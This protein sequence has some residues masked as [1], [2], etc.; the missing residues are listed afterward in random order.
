MIEED[1]G[2][3]PPPL[4]ITT[5]TLTNAGVGT[6]YSAALGSTGGTAPINWTLAS[7]NLPAGL[8]L[9]SVGVISGTPTTS[10][11]ATFT[12][13]AADSATQTA[14][15]QLSL[16]VNATTLAITTAT[17]PNGTI[18]VAYS[19]TVQTGGGTAPVTLAHTAGSLPPGLTFSAGTISGT[20]TTVGSSSFTI[21]ATDAASQSVSRGFQLVI[22]ATPLTITTTSLTSGT[23]GVAYNAT[24]TASGGTAPRTWNLAGGTLPA[25]VSLNAA[26]AISGTPTATGSFTFNA[27]VTDAAGQSISRQFVLTINPPALSI[28]TPSLP[29]GTIGSAYSTGIATSGGVPPVTLTLASGTLPA[30]LGLAGATISGTPTTA[31]TSTFTIRATDA[32]AQ[33]V[34]RQFQIM[35]ASTPLVITSSALANG[36]TG[37]A[38][39]ANLAATGGVTPYDWSVSAGSLPA[40]LNLSAAGAITGTPTAF[41]TATFTAQVTDASSQVQARQFSLTV[42][43]PAVVINTATLPNAVVNSAYTTSIAVSGGIA[44]YA[45][46]LSSG[47]LPAG[48]NLNNGTGAISGTPTV[49]G[50][51]TFTISV[52]DASAQNVSRQFTLTVAPTS[53]VITTTGL[54]SGTNGVAYSRTLAA[55]GGVPGYTWNIVGSLPTGLALNAATGQISGTPTVNGTSTFVA[56]VT[57]TVPQTVS[58]QLSITINASNLSIDTL[59]LPDG[60]VS[61]AYN[62]TLV[63]SGGTAPYT[64]SISAGAAPSGLTLSAAG[65]LSGTPTATG[66]FNFTAQ[67]AD[68]G[69]QTS[70]RAFSVTINPGTLQITTLTLPNS[71][72]GQAYNQTV[73]ATGG[74]IPYTWSVSVG[75][76][77]NGLNLNAATGAITGT[78]TTP[79]DFTF[80]I[81]NADSGSQIATR[82]YTVNIA[83]TSLSLVTASLPSGQVSVAYNQTLTATGGTLGYTWSIVNGNLP[84]GLNLNAATGAITGTPTTVETT[85]P[86]IRVTDSANQRAQR[87]FTIQIQSVTLQITTTSTPD[88]VVGSAYNTTLTST[89]GVAP[90]TWTISSG[91]LPAGITLSSAGVLSGSATAAGTFTFT[92]R[93][94]DSTSQAATRQFTITATAAPLT[95]TTSSLPDG[96]IAVAYNTTLAASGGAPPLTWSVVAGAL[97]P[98]LSLSAAG[99]ISG[100]PTTFG[101]FS[102][103]IRVADTASQNAQ[104]QFTLVVMPPPL[105]ITTSSVPDTVINT[106][107]NK[108]LTSSGGAAPI[109][110]A[111]VGGTL[112]PGLSLSAGGVISGTSTTSGTFLFTVQASDSA[113]QAATRQFTINVSATPLVLVTTALPDAQVNIGYTTI[114]S[115]SGGAQPYSWAIVSGSLPAG[116]TLSGG[117][118]IDGTASTAGTST[119][120]IRVTDAASQTAQR[121]FTLSVQPPPLSVATTTLPNGNVGSAYNRTIL[122]NGGTPPYSWS[123]IAG[124]LPTGLSLNSTTGSVTG[125]PTTTGSF[126]F[127]V[128]VNDSAGQIATRNLVINI[129]PVFRILTLTIPGGIENQAYSETIQAADNIGAVTWSVVS[130]SLPPGL[131]VSP[132]TGILS[133]TPVTVG[134]FTFTVQAT[135]GGGGIVSQAYLQIISPNNSNYGNVGD[136]YADEGGGPAAGATTLTACGSLASNTSYRLIQSV[137][138][139]TPSTTCFNLG[140]NT[141]L[142]LS[143]HTVTGR[144]VRNGNVNGSTIFNGTINCLANDSGGNAGC[145]NLLSVSTFV[146]P[147]KLHHLTITNTGAPSRAIHI[148]WP[149]SSPASSVTVRMYN[150]T[151]SVGTQP[152]VSRSHALSFTGGQHFAEILNNNLTCQTDANACQAIVC[153]NT[154]DC[155]MHHNRVE[156]IQNSTAET[157]RALV[158]QGA[159]NGEAWNNLIIANDNRGFR[160]RDSTNIRVHH[161]DFQLI[162]PNAGLGVIHLGDPDSGDNDLN[163]LIDKNN[164]QLAGGTVVFIRNAFNATVRSNAFSCVGNCSTSKLADVRTPSG[165]GTRSELTVENNPD[166]VLYAAPPH[167]EVDTGARATVCNS[168]TAG[169]GGT[170]NIVSVCP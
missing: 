49:T 1:P 158:Y 114:L 109:V 56:E 68:S 45:F 59:A 103:T 8:N 123:V 76:I 35:I 41:G 108:T 166:I 74:T 142:D 87:Q 127:R 100:T 58:K 168:G 3:P 91:A 148:D 53:L 156:M 93:V 105:Q 155:K 7:G 36:T 120:T 92:A 150:I 135:D 31:G 24:L 94:A 125:T 145:I 18:G 118:V 5:T 75:A 61:T 170:I 66:T 119:L 4:A 6:P 65:V 79:G 48:V 147:L 163:V 10:G 47:A 89:G 19:V 60:Q 26:G 113:M 67:V 16:T 50:N 140:Q 73:N 152:T 121:Q 106:A 40:G 52:S 141:K 17:L 139:T 43:A 102:A 107:Y 13:Q 169:G 83:P 138:A 21:T 64:F 161:N 99:V 146:A 46:N 77:P 136:P 12:V 160:M 72:A 57:D 39:N 167:V 101:S 28:T 86:R 85:T 9:S 82:Q 117:G 81:R 20:P 71:T 63:A 130:G 70:T 29:N 97:P 25:G 124:T 149:L 2:T 37:S 126:A 112:P 30:G 115:A 55:T 137:A 27:R 154:S 78:P 38:Y 153:L 157:G 98:G 132:S 165:S 104:R 14:T 164:F 162:T 131:T 128:Q 134:T 22:N 80:T 69:A 151:A 62:Q 133:G 95:L 33:T 32:A 111:L 96:Q 44:P 23:L 42:N 110:W 51:F 11:T 54:P 15:R 144:I 34:T 88:T 122:A 159:D 129:V 84:A 116:M 143:G 90:F